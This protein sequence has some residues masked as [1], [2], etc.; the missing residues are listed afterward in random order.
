MDPPGFMYSN[1]AKI[2]TP[3]T[4]FNHF[5]S[6]MGVFPMDANMEAVIIVLSTL[7][8]RFDFQ[9]HLRMSCQILLSLF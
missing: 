2:L 6:T 3:G 9:I 5:I 4:G 7:A 8:I 1:L